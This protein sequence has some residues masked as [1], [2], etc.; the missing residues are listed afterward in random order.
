MVLVGDVQDE[1]LDPVFR[2]RLL[3]AFTDT[4]GSW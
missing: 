4:V 1:H 3:K 2:E